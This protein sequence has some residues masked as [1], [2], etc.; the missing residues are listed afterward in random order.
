MIAENESIVDLELQGDRKLLVL[1]QTGY[2]T[3]KVVRL[4]DTG[5]VDRGFNWQGTLSGPTKIALQNDGK[6]LVTG[7]SSTG[8]HFGRF[9]SDGTV[10]STFTSR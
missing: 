4:N 3:G 1:Q 8:I 2:E 7:S 6:F 5:S 10:D 9:H